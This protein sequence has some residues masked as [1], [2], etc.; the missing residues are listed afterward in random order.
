[1]RLRV[2]ISHPLQALVMDFRIYKTLCNNFFVSGFILALDLQICKLSAMGLVPS[3]LWVLCW[4]G[5][6]GA[7]FVYLSGKS[8]FNMLGVYLFGQ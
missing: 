4:T 3:E 5:V 2:L 7:Q 6:N 8:L 1:M